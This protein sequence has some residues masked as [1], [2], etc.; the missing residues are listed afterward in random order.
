MMVLMV[1]SFILLGL[2]SGCFRRIED[3]PARDGHFAGPRGTLGVE[4]A[5]PLTIE[6][7]ASLEGVRIAVE[8]AVGRG[9]PTAYPE[10]GE[11]G[12]RV[13]IF[14]D[15]SIFAEGMVAEIRPG[16]RPGIRPLTRSAS[17]PEPV[18]GV[19]PRASASRPVRLRSDELALAAVVQ[20]SLPAGLVEAGTHNL[21]G[22]VRP[23]GFP[24][25]V[26]L[27]VET[28]IQVTA[29]P[30][31]DAVLTAPFSEQ[32]VRPGDVFLPDADGDGL[33]SL[34]EAAY[35]LIAGGTVGGDPDTL[36]HALASMT[37]P[38]RRPMDEDVWLAYGGLG[39]VLEAILR[40]QGVR[41]E[42][43]LVDLDLAAPDTGPIEAVDAGGVVLPSGSPTDART[44]IFSFGCNEIDCSFRCSVD[45]LTPAQC[46]APFPLRVL[47]EGDHTLFVRAA[48]RMG[49]ADSTPSTFLWTLDLTEPETQILTAPSTT[50]NESSATFDFTSS[51]RVER[52]ECSVDE[53]I[54]VECTSPRVLDSL[55]DG[56][57][58]FRVRAVDSA[59]NADSTPAFHLWIVDTEAPDGTTLKEAP[60]A[61][62]KKAAARFTFSNPEPTAMFECALDTPAYFPCSTPLEATVSS[63]GPHIFQVRALDRAGNAESPIPTHS[64][65]VDTTPPLDTAVSIQSGAV[66]TTS[67]SV[68]LTLSATGASEMQIALDG[69]ADTEPFETYAGSKFVTLPA[70]DGSRTVT[71]VFRDEAGN[72][73]NAQDD[74]VV[75]TTPPSFNGIQSATTLCSDE[76]AL[77][78]SSGADALSFPDE[79]SYEVCRSTTSGG[80][81][82]PWSAT[83][84][85]S[86]GA[87]SL[88]ATG[89]IQGTTYHFVVRARDRYGNLSANTE[90]ASATTSQLSAPAQTRPFNGINTGVNKRPTFT[91]TSVTCADEYELQGDDT[92]TFSTGLEI[93]PSSLTTVSHTP[94]SDLPVSMVQPVG[95]RYFWRVRAKDAAGNASSWSAI[96]Y[97]NVGRF[98][99]DF[100]GDGYSDWLVG[101]AF[102][103]AGGGAGANRGQ[104]Y[105]LLGGV[106]PNGAVDLTL[107]GD[108]NASQ[109]GF[110]VATA[111]DVNADGYSDWLIAAHLRD[112]GG[113]DRGCVFLFLG[114]AALDGTADLTVCD[115]EN[116]AHFGV[117]V[118]G[119]GDVNNDGYSD[120]VAGANLHDA[121]GGPGTDRGQA[122]LYLGGSPPD[123]IADL[124]LL[125]DEDQARFGASASAAG[126]VNGD[127]YSDWMVGA[128]WHDA[129]GTDRGRVYL[130]FGGSA[131]DT[132]ADLIVSGDTD[133]GEF[134]NHMASAGDVNG[135]GYGDW[136]IGAYKHPGGG[137]ERGRAYLF[138][139]GATPDTTV[140]LTFTGDQDNVRLGTQVSSAGDADADGYADWVISAPNYTA[141]QGRVYV[142]RGGANPN[143]NADLTI[144]G[145]E[146][147]AAHGI[148]LSEAGDVNADGKSDWAAGASAHDGGGG[149]GANRG[150]AYVYF[151]GSTLNDTPDVTSSGD[152]NDCLFGAA[153]N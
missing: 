99:A 122:Y 76:I 13:D 19:P 117:S 15:G 68:T 6:Q 89:L 80:C 24:D 109:L 18:P 115:T 47:E 75:D 32:I 42:V 27:E 35:A 55:T 31:P 57:H 135:D 94:T 79:I 140:D 60:A 49:N 137:T 92:A 142:F 14:W 71:V 1:V 74:I 88:T 26:L 119:V 78:W 144:N 38:Q 33:A 25:L 124:T 145:D 46:S 152:E 110:Q 91:W 73:S 128:H 40:S 65:M 50:N 20:F 63:D 44:L 150:R 111:G 87:T 84:T 16:V 113:V 133:N 85:T 41:T 36:E 98:D 5:V 123:G 121:A 9:D 51:E 21:T 100:N 120:W 4:L 141:N 2:L 103:D 56:A 58:S 151:G 93:N 107:S 30:D 53:S 148:A 108:E 81:V 43:S 149:A 29:S 131:L 10:A 83:Y 105:V 97:I 39:D 129:G 126:D 62:S 3:L 64:W 61:L 54:Y 102:H 23:E 86:P 28:P 22:R 146:G 48:D 134:G 104:A 143:A 153:V 12:L 112:G 139:G 8:E 66:Y 106:V 17:T 96:R 118:A 130:Y 52:F 67:L 70:G 77:T 127:G 37:D 132:T 90:Q 95:T 138:L 59:E 114:S 147:G 82:S 11:G 72:T 101:A 125:G 45:G 34:I 116:F 7:A 136:I 69:T